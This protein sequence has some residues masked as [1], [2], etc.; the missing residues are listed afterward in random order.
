MRRAAIPILLL[1]LLVHAGA[2]ARDHIIFTAN[3]EFLSRIYVLTM[4]GSVERHFEYEFYRWCDMEVVDGELYVAEAFA[5]R[6]YRVDI[7]TGDLEV[8]VDDWSLYYFYGLAF[9]GAYLYTD[10]WN[11]NRYTIDGVKDGTASFDGD[12]FG[13]AWDGAYLYTLDDSGVALCWDISAWPSLVHLPENDIPVPSVDC[14]GLFFDGEWFWSAE[15]LEGT[16]GMIYRFD[17][18]GTVASQWPAPAYRGWG[19]CLLRGAT[20][21]VEPASDREALR[22]ALTG[23]NPVTG[24]VKLTLETADPRRVSVRVYDV[25][26]RRVATLLDGECAPGMHELIW[27]AEDVAS[28]VYFVRAWDGRN[29]AASRV[30][31]LR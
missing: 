25:A 26:G 16:P 20:G 1:T 21:V 6:V 9:D 2:V 19:A 13:C 11:L 5:P 7:E 4:D 22:I 30:V 18:E 28:G 29:E 15:S 8:V 17:H 10:E 14:R 31:V 3:Q 24:Q 23:P 27:S 12:V